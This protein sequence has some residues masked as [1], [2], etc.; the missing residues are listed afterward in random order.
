MLRRYS[1]ALVVI[2]EQK[3]REAMASARYRLAPSCQETGTA[4]RSVG[5]R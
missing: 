3:N 1:P 2:L 5:K 4:C